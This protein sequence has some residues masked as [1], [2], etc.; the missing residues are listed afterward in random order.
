M[1][2]YKGKPSHYIQMLKDYFRE[3]FHILILYFQTFQMLKLYN[4]RYRNIEKDVQKKY[5]VVIFQFW[6]TIVKPTST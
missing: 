4:K 6:F 5:T 2:F 3:V 1:L